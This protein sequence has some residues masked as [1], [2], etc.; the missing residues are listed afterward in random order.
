[1]IYVKKEWKL[2]TKNCTSCRG[3]ILERQNRNKFRKTESQEKWRTNNKTRKHSY[4]SSTI[5]STA[6]ETSFLGPSP[7]RLSR[8]QFLYPLF[9]ANFTPL[10]SLIS[11]IRL[12]FT[13]N[14]LIA[15]ILLLPFALKWEI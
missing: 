1:M 7:S 10:L 2:I 11:L 9:F 14:L 8:T 5:Y 6:L 15:T 12:P 3:T 4:T 13:S